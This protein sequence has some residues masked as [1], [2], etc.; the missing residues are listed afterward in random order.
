M[1]A[2]KI[3]AQEA[4]IDL[5]TARITSLVERLEQAQTQPQRSGGSIGE[6]FARLFLPCANLCNSSCVWRA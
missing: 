3:A 6:M 5:L 1:L 4:S 2:S